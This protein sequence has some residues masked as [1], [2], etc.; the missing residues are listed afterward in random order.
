MKKI[1][2]MGK[3]KSKVKADIKDIIKADKA[4]IRADKKAEKK[5]E[6][7]ASSKAEKK[8]A[9]NA[10]VKVNKK[11]SFKK[12]AIPKVFSSLRIK[13][14]AAFMVPIAFII[15]LGIISFLESAKGIQGNYEKSTGQV[16][17]MTGEYLFFGVESIEN[18]SAEYVN[19]RDIVNYKT[20]SNVNDKLELKKIQTG[21]QSML[22]T[23]SKTDQFISNIY[24]I[25]N[26]V[27][28][29][30]SNLKLSAK[31]GE[32]L[33]ESYQETEA[34]KFLSENKVK[35]L[36]VG[37][38]TFL[39]EKLETTAQDYALRL[40]RNLPNRNDMLVIDIEA[41]AVADILKNIN[42]DKDGYLNFVTKDGKEITAA[43]VSEPVFSN[44]DFYQKAISSE[45]TS[46]SNYVDYKGNS[47][48]FVYSKIGE[49]GAMLC[50][51]MPKSTI[52]SQAD[53][54]KMV[55]IIVVIIACV[56]AVLIAFLFSLG[57]DRTIKA[58]IKNLKK[59]AKGDLTVQF[60]T[61]RDDEF[62]VLID[63]IQ[64]T[65]SNVK[66][67]IQQVNDLSGMVSDSASGLSDTASSFVK[68]TEEIS[69]A[70]NEIEQ[71]VFQQA[72]DAEQCLLQ[73]D[74]LSKKIAL[75]SENTK[76]ISQIANTTKQSVMDGTYCTEDLNK[77]TKA[78]IDITTGIIAAIEK[79][80]TKTQ[81]ITKISNVISGIT[82]QTNL[83]SLNASIEA[84][85]AGAF[86]RGFAVVADEI[87][88]LAEQSKDS[89]NEIQKIISSIQEDTR[90]AV[91]IA[92]EA[93][94]VL[95]KQ[96]NVVKNTTDSY[97]N[98]NQSVE[99]LVVY[100]KQISENVDNIEESR[101]STLSAIESISAVLEEVAASSNSVNQTAGH[102]IASVED[103]NKSATTLNV[104]AN[105]L[106]HAV[107][108]F[109]I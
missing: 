85:R 73:M 32:G 102:Q 81:E 8:A 33:Y 71:G 88:H 4:A 103:L 41:Q 40:I 90:S 10:E 19:N 84:A 21:L 82:A 7:I 79:L 74:N 50:A 6:K 64:G 78:T 25:F 38:D 42:F 62:K 86:G 75:V 14:I 16:V 94:N 49:T 52:T 76:E 2:W 37:N 22:N 69:D 1:E 27:S 51:L 29:I 39:D 96:E 98:I 67:L 105:E 65:F 20:A 58:I 107:Q 100:L 44:L 9:I 35:S 70:M 91:A 93:E 55:T 45:K 23:K 83:L 43:G 15:V 77:Q 18:I 97:Q 106:H 5:V 109:S 99:S 61:N 87:R 46:D 3:K 31:V 59:A 36:W 108:K 89:V 24:L 34:G 56:I 48:L 11:I 54:I 101:V 68:S 63:E 72:K 92:K 13:L 66:G 47:Y 26:E 57:I 53:Q 12:I 80:A 30:S 95:G 28:S 104:N 60:H 17:S